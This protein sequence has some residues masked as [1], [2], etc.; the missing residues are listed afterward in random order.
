MSIRRLATGASIVV[1]I[2][3]V[4]NACSSSA[5]LPAGAAVPADPR[6]DDGALGALAPSDIIGTLASGQTSVPTHYV[7]P[8]RYR[9]F[10]FHGRPGDSSGTAI[11]RQD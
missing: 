4:A 5:A 9:A 10:S 8:P 11:A 2:A 3:A 1:L 6:T 7:N